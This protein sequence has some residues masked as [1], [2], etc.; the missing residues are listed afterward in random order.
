MYLTYEEVDKKR[1][2]NKMLVKVFLV[3]VAV[4]VPVAVS[5]LVSML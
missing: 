5:L 2:R 1:R 3:G 4:S